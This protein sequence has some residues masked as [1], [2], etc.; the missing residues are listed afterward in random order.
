MGCSSA[1][2]LK[3]ASRS[4]SGASKVW[5]SRRSRSPGGFLF[6]RSNGG[7][8]PRR[9]VLSEHDSDNVLPD[10]ARYVQPKVTEARLARVWA[11]VDARLPGRQRSRRVWG[12]VGA[13]VL[14][15]AAATG[16]FFLVGPGYQS[17]PDAESLL[18]GAVLE[19]ASDSLSMGLFDG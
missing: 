7:L 14:A 6:P 1:C 5:R 4:Y 12:W 10:V 3:S 16:V 17:T 19:T 13:G 9:R 11:G 8:R 15:A 2:R 18:A